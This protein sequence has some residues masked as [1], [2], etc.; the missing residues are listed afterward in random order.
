[1]KST[2]EVAFQAIIRGRVQGV[3][4]RYSTRSQAQRL[5]ITG[6]VKNRADGAVE[7]YAEGSREDLARFEEWLRAGP[8]YA[9]VTDVEI[10]RPV[11]VGSYTRFSVEF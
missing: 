7:V 3:G 11:P 6:W 4:F 8:P 9:H 2:D 5:G 1:M 10:S